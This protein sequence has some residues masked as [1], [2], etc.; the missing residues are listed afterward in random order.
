MVFDGFC[1]MKDVL[2]QTRVP[3]DYGEWV[4]KAAEIDGVS[5]AAWL[6]RLVMAEAQKMRVEAWVVNHGK[7]NPIAYV[8]CAP[9]PASYFLELDQRFSQ[10]RKKT[11]AMR[12]GPSHNLPGADVKAEWLSRLSWF[13]DFG[14][15]WFLLK[16]S[17]NP[18]SVVETIF[19]ET[20][21]TVLI[22]L[23][24]DTTTCFSDKQKNGCDVSLRKPR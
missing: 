1:I 14:S 16:G 8:N 21:S 4:S 6:R 9:P 19:D 24:Q 11:F 12:H 17:P 18:W 5:V 2:L 7:E 22:T 23:A 10:E 20:K 3:I 13:N 15:V